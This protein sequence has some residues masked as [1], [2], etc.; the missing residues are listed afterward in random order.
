MVVDTFAEVRESDVLNLAQELDHNLE[1]DKKILQKIFERLDIKQKGEL[2]LDELLEGARRDPE[3]QSRLRVM[4]IDEVD[5]RQLFEMIDVD[6][7]GA[8]EVDEFIVPLSRWVHDSKTAPRFIK[9]NLMHAMHQQAELLELS[10]CNF[11]WMM[12][13]LDELAQQMGTQ[14]ECSSFSTGAGFMPRPPGPSDLGG[15]ARPPPPPQEG[16]EGLEQPKPSKCPPSLQLPPAKL[17]DALASAMTALK[18]S[19][20]RAV[21]LSLGEVEGILQTRF[22]ELGRSLNVQL[23]IAPEAAA[24]ERTLISPSKFPTS[25]PGHPDRRV[26]PVRREDNTD[27]VQAQTEG[28]NVARN[29]PVI[30]TRPGKPPDDPSRFQSV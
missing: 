24:R 20:S 5:L 14:S 23:P 15:L 16:A 28:P 7:S 13:R 1:I 6:G 25:V 19:L 27:R 3:F 26:D 18:D 9:Y 12:Q 17:D 30:V 21:Q 8:I 22:E 2:T 10:R 4:D 11:S 29:P